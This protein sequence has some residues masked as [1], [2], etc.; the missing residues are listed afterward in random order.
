MSNLLSPF[1]FQAGGGAPTAPDAPTNVVGTRGNT[2]VSVAF[3][4]PA[5]DGGSAIISYTATSSPGGFTATGASSPLVVTGLTNGTP[6]TFT[7]TADNAVGES[8]PSS[9][10]AAVTPATVP[11]A[12]TIGT[13]T[14]GDEE[15]S[16]TFSAP[17][18]NGGEAIT[19]YTAT[20]SPSGITG[21]GGS[22]P[23]VITGLT[24]GV[25][26]TV[27]VTATNAV[28]TGSASA[29]SNAVTPEAA[30]GEDPYAFYAGLD[31]NRIP[32]HVS[33]GDWGVQDSFTAPTLPT[34]SSTVTVT[35]DSEFEAAYNAGVKVIID[36]N[37]T[38]RFLFSPLTDMEFQ[39]ND[40]VVCDDFTF[41]GGGARIHYHG[42]TPG[43]LTTS[44][45]KFNRVGSGGAGDYDD[46]VFDGL[47]STASGGVSFDEGTHRAAVVRCAFR[48]PDA[49]F[50]GNGNAHDVVI[51][52]VNAVGGAGW[53]LRVEHQWLRWCVF[54]CHFRSDA[55]AQIRPGMNATGQPASRVFV[56]MDSTLTNSTQWDAGA[57]GYVFRTSNSSGE[58]V[59]MESV[60]LI[61]NRVHGQASSGGGL[62]FN[63]TTGRVNY[64]RSTDNTI[65][66]DSGGYTFP[67][68]G[69]GEDW[70]ETGRVDLVTSGNAIPA[71]NN[72]GNA[73]DPT[74]I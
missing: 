24:N 70:A 45:G 43:T 49:I 41:I 48:E 67:T 71:W 44:S 26:Q 19:V 10:S 9:A 65:V 63:P 40:G 32:A 47:L 1:W 39:I 4:A 50:N 5:S 13:A 7:V 72:H 2:Q 12:P 46:I 42:E 21:A 68:P 27:T 60:W 20:A 30:G 22:S 6:Y 36:G 25:E 23:I 52:G 54:E 51:A 73:V 3:D 31:L 56:V 62:E 33:S 53:I 35:D 15:I 59:A 14:A 17:G 34:I 28:G 16:I 8:D 69:G 64:F 37:L 74:G 29:A 66:N 58:T 57:D 38:A 61:N 11:G 55:N 18:S